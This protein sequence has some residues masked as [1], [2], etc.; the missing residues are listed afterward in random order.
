MLGQRTAV[1]L[2]NLIQDFNVLRPLIYMAR[3]QFGYQILILVSSKFRGRDLFG[4][5]EAELAILREETDARTFVYGHEFDAFRMLK[6]SGIIFS[7]SESSVP[8]HGAAHALFRY[9]PPTFLKVTLQHG[10][11]CVG[12]RHSAAHDLAYGKTA[13]FAADFVCSW[14]PPELQP[15]L[16][17]SQRAKVRVT[18]STAVL[19]A[20]QD[21]ITRP[22]GAPGLVCENLHSVRLN[23]TAGVKNEFVASFTEFCRLM[24]VDGKQVALR[25]HPGGQYV[26]KHEVELPANVTIE[27]APMHRI[28]LRRFAYGVSA[29]SS[30]LIDML[31]ADVPTAVWSDTGRSVD[32]SNYADLPHVSTPR[33]WQD[34]AR[35]AAVRPEPLV[36]LQR[37]F[38]L[39]QQIPTDPADVFQ[40]FAAILRGADAINVR[41]GSM[42]ERRRFLI[43]SNAHLP[44]VQVCLE[45]PLEPLVRSGEMRVELLTEHRLLQEQSR[46][47][48][49]L[50]MEEWLGRA[51]DAFDADAVIFSRYSGPF[52]DQILEWSKRNAVPAIYH[53]DDDLLGV[54][55]SLGEA[56]YAY[57]NAPE[58]IGAVR[59]L[60]KE[61]DLVY[62]STEVLRRRLID[63][64]PDLPA[65]AGAI[66]CSGR[67]MRRA[68]A[69]AAKV[70]GYMAS[71][72]HLPNLQMVLPAIVALLDR[73]PD[74][75]FELFGSIPVPAELDRFGG[76][77]RKLE[78][79]VEY[80]S[81]LG[82]LGDRGWDIGI[83]PLVPTPFNMAKSN[84]KWV[85]YSALGI[86]VVASAETIYDDCCAD[87]CGLLAAGL[88]EWTASLERLVTDGAGRVDMVGRAQHKLQSVYGIAQHR[89]QILDV[90]EQ[91]RKR[92]AA[93]GVKEDA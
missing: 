21:P 7:A 18:G 15:S 68:Q 12:F 67:P 33:E 89:R 5:W 36:E 8:E 14:Q 69:G 11:E 35:E 17:L 74:L 83:C 72:D 38:L 9:A 26:L 49:G 61:A 40:R 55:K 13:S 37:R 59:H 91:A 29:P 52:A 56:K 77:V 79:V 93:S 27:N 65:I 63:E 41:G 4:M 87:G 92:V 88:D 34:F 54:P 20:F 78:P 25:P 85:E 46:L 22:P 31:L 42:A 57:H 3:R 73:H 6:G 1:F 64:F 16:A 10:F 86:A 60:L 24:E 19:Q 80:E 2:M 76:R 84:N 28:D 90:V 44:T 30:V 23:A 81:F 51:L 58:R 70:F 39:D 47:G 62:V 82:A 53:I 32:T 50:A 43:V 66:N 45:R 48:A 75:A 71:A